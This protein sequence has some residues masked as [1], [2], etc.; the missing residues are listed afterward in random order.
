VASY[1]NKREGLTASDVG[2]AQQA[3]LFDYVSRQ[4]KQ[5]L[6]IDSKRFLANPEEQL[7]ALCT[8][9]EIEFHNSML[10]WPAGPRDTDGVWG[11]HWYDAVNKSTGFA[12]PGNKAVTLTESQQ[13]IAAICQ[14]YYDAMLPYAL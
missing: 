5:P 3:A 10:S 12:K 1:A 13:R 4:Q 11:E 2:Y 14:P 6:V 9:L 8:A 7:R